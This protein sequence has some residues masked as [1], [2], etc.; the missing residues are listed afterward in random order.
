MRP[1]A[2]RAAWLFSLL[3]APP[4]PNPANLRG[5]EPRLP[6]QLVLE[7]RRRPLSLTAP[8]R[9]TRAVGRVL[10]SFVNAGSAAGPRQALLAEA[11]WGAGHRTIGG[12]AKRTLHAGQ[13][14]AAAK[15]TTPCHIIYT[16]QDSATHAGTQARMRTGMRRFYTD[17]PTPKTH[18]SLCTGSSTPPHLL[19]LEWAG[20]Q[21]GVRPCKQEYLSFQHWR[22]R[23]LRPCRRATPAQTRRPHLSHLSLVSGS[24]PARLRLCNPHR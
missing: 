11:A 8:P 2:A 12:A 20:V 18:D 10:Q 16:V 13:L 5:A 4:P 6:V 23:A 7:S 9:G 17:A 3:R 21:G 19:L 15:D 22:F 24:L 1:A 14:H